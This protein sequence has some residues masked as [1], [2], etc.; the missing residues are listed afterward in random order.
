M[1]R[2]TEA[3]LDSRLEDNASSPDCDYESDNEYAPRTDGRRLARAIQKLPR[4]PQFPIPNIHFSR[5][6]V[7]SM[8]EHAKMGPRIRQRMKLHQDRSRKDEKRLSKSGLKG[9]HAAAY[10]DIIDEARLITDSVE[11]LIKARTTTTRR[12]SIATAL[13]ASTRSAPCEHT[14]SLRVNDVQKSAILDTGATRS[15]NRRN[16]LLNFKNV[17]N[18]KVGTA[19]GSCVPVVGIGDW[20]SPLS[21]IKVVP[22]RCHGRSFQPRFERPL[23]ALPSN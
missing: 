20:S 15:G 4:A 9:I 17:D 3:E 23:V 12:S 10:Q 2:Q 18:R 22:S 16:E 5:E 7:R 6:E 14:T 13:I 19:D 11:R 8:M 1:L 21:I